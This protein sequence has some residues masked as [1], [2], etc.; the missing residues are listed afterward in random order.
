M[1]L[2]LKNYCGFSRKVNQPIIWVN[3]SKPFKKPEPQGG[4]AES[5][6]LSLINFRRHANRVTVKKAFKAELLMA[7]CFPR[8]SWL[9]I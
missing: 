4:E 1:N 3:V 5:I 6:T 2:F 7:D 8:V 9:K